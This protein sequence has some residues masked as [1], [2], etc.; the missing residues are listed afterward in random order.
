MVKRVEQQKI[1]ACDLLDRLVLGEP[2][3]DS[4]PINDCA[5]LMR[6]GLACAEG[7]LVSPLSRGK[8]IFFV[9]PKDYDAALAEDERRRKENEKDSE[10]TGFGFP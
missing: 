8:N 1:T 6:A 9:R 3:K 7:H 5:L 2:D 10:I 4:A